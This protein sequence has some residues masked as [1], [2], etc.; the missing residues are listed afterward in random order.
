MFVCY[1]L[2]TL[3]DLQKAE[4]MGVPVERTE[5]PAKATVSHEYHTGINAPSVWYGASFYFFF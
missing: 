1:I 2:V 4:L 5:S 3:F